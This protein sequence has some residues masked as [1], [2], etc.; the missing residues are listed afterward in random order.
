MAQSF[1][2]DLTK[3]SKAMNIETVKIHKFDMK[4]LPNSGVVS[5]IGKDKQ[6][7]RMCIKDILKHKCHFEEAIVVCGS[8]ATLQKLPNI[9]SNLTIY[10]YWDEKKM[11]E[12]YLNQVQKS[13]CQEIHRIVI[14]VESMGFARDMFRQGELME[15]IFANAKEVQ[16]LLLVSMETC[17]QVSLSMRSQISH[18]FITFHAGL[19]PRNTLFSMTTQFFKSRTEFNDAAQPIRTTNQMMVINNESVDKTKIITW[20]KNKSMP[21]V[22]PVREPLTKSRMVEFVGE[23]LMFGKETT[24]Q[25]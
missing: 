24:I 17:H 9:V 15:Q 16:I 23:N 19:D 7:K 25:Y 18:T 12:I 20:Y 21:I 14:L 11:S 1:S 6:K 3:N 5:I 22:F 2:H 10:D 4:T 13:R 8:G